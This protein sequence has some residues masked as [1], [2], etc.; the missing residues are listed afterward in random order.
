MTS[1]SSSLLGQLITSCTSL[2]RLYSTTP[3]PLALIKS[4]PP[5]NLI[6]S[7]QH[8]SPTRTGLL[9]RASLHTVSIT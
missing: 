9:V 4:L 7:Y 6:V 5:H 2:Q 1:I 3:C 8:L